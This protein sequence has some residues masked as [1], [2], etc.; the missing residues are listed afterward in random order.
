MYFGACVYTLH[1]HNHSVIIN[2]KLLYRW[3][4]N[5]TINVTCGPVPPPNT[6]SYQGWLATDD[7][8]FSCPFSD[9]EYIGG[10]RITSSPIEW[11]FECFSLPD[12]YTLDECMNEEVSAVNEGRV[13][14]AL[15]IK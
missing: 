4:D 14:T 3:S 11:W 12:D 13:M 10:I 9:K 6:K 5:I 15:S 7:G 8:W 1:L 2:Y